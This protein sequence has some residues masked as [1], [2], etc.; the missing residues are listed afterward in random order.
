MGLFDRLFGSR[1]SSRAARPTTS[2]TQPPSR[3]V[4]SP[5]QANH[6]L[7]LAI[8]RSDAAAVAGQLGQGANANALISN[9]TVDF[10][11][12][13]FYFNG[14]LDERAHC[15]EIVE[16]LL[17]HGADANKTDSSGVPPLVFA[18]NQDNGRLRGI[19]E[20]V[21]LLLE[22]GADVN[23]ASPRGATPLCCAAE[24]GSAGL[25]NSLLSAG[26]NPNSPGVDG[27]A[28]LHAAL[29]VA[30]DDVSVAASLI[31]AGADVNFVNERQ[32]RSLLHVAAKMGKVNFVNL[33][34]DS[35][36][37][38]AWKADGVNTALYQAVFDQQDAVAQTL[39][40]HGALRFEPIPSNL[41][42]AA[43]KSDRLTDLLVR[44]GV[45][46]PEGASLE[47]YKERRSRAEHVTQ[48]TQEAVQELTGTDEVR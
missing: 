18:L 3:T 29:S 19:A 21:E 46:P 48:V 24:L 33:L 23:A 25:V 5:S 16:L 36:V 22:H 32:D 42:V 38:I 26:A 39:L 17:D 13:T 14:R 11:P 45:T 1:A 6:N 2:P 9:G 31:D 15:P 8:H 27:W 44:H 7:L 35:G 20:I 40:E 37:D 12:L 10:T 34:I 47:D 43:A 28:P 30:G 41:L 4:S